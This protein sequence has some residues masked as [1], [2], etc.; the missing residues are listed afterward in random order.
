MIHH[1]PELLISDTVN[2]SNPFSFIDSLQ[3]AKEIGEADEVNLLNSRKLVLLVDL[4]QTIIH[5]TNRPF[6]HDPNKVIF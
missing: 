2:Y 3:L 5:T 1:V 4:D 6:Q